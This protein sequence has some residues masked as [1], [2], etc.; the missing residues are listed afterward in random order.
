[1]V[2]SLLKLLVAEV[3][4]NQ[5][6]PIPENFETFTDL[7]KD[8]TSHAGQTIKSSKKTSRNDGR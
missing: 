2:F 1:M 8:F 5:I 3:I 6:K 7:I 4:G